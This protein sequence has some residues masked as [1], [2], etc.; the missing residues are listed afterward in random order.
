VTPWGQVWIDG[1]FMGRAPV[2]TRVSAGTHVVAAGVDRPSVRRRVQVT[3][4]RTQR[5][6]LEVPDR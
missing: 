3:A 6:V 1:K 4:D 5:V 2:V